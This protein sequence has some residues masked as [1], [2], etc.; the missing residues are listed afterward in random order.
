ME[1]MGNINEYA[2]FS[3][4]KKQ[5]QNPLNPIRIFGEVT[6]MNINYFFSFLKGITSICPNSSTQDPKMAVLQRGLHF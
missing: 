5:Q 3:Q 1:G 6:V 4:A 2:L